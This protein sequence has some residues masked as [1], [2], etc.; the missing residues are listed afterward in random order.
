MLQ[1]SG[2]S[3]GWG[4]VRGAAAQLLDV[5]SENISF[6]IFYPTVLLK[7]LNTET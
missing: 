7:L 2:L 1:H 3:A 5:E 6:S 4:L